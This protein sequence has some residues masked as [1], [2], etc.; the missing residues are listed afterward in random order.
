MQFP[1]STVAA[2]LAFAVTM[3]AFAADSCDAL[4][5]AGVKSIRTPHHV[6]STTTMRDGKAQSGEA[7]YAGGV[8]YIKLAGQWKR[9]PMTPQ[10]MI[11]AAQEKLKT[12]PDTCTLVG[13]Q[14]VDGQA[15]AVYKAHN[16][17]TGA[18]QLV[19]IL[20]SSGLMQGGSLK[21]SDGLM[22]ETRYDY[23]NVQ[24]PGGVK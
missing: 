8:E 14:T 1:I 21:L 9:S 6:Y 24:A 2:G 17:K 5:Q 16:N 4:Y 20:K 22:V 7:I 13:E 15:V 3:P 23:A 19:R 11:E 18:D 10:D 12:H